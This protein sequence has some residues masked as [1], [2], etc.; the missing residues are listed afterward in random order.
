MKQTSEQLEQDLLAYVDGRLCPADAARI[1]VY[2]AN[3]DPEQSARVAG[4]IADRERLRALPPLRAPRDLAERIMERV[5]RASLLG[6]A[7]HHSSI[8]PRRW[9]HHHMA[10]AA[11]LIFVFGLFGAFIIHSVGQRHSTW[12]PNPIANGGNHETGIP[13]AMAPATKSGDAALPVAF[14]DKEHTVQKGASTELVVK[15]G[16]GTQFKPGLDSSEN[17]V[18]GTYNLTVLEATNQIDAVKANFNGAPNSAA[19]L[20][21]VGATRRDYVAGSPVIVVL[22]AR[23]GSD[24]Q[25]LRSLIANFL[26]TDPVTADRQVALVSRLNAYDTNTDLNANAQALGAQNLDRKQVGN[27]NAENNRG[28]AGIQQQFT[29]RNNDDQNAYANQY[30]VAGPAQAL[31][32]NAS[33][34]VRTQLQRVATEPYRN[35]KAAPRS[36]IPVAFLGDN[37]A[38]Y[39]VLLR[40]EQL[41]QVTNQF[42]V[43]SIA[44][45]NTGYVIGNNTLGANRALNYGIANNGY[46]VA[47]GGNLILNGSNTLSATGNS[48]ILNNGNAN[49]ANTAGTNTTTSLNSAGPSPINSKD[50]APSAG[51]SGSNVEAATVNGTLN[52]NANGSGSANNFSGGTT[53]TGGTLSAGAGASGA[54][55]GLTFAP[56]A[57]PTPNPAPG[58]N[59]APTVSEDNSHG[60]QNVQRPV[61]GLTKGSEFRQNGGMTEEQPSNFK[62]D[63]ALR[64]A[65]Q[66]QGSRTVQ[67]SERA[68]GV[69]QSE[70]A[71]ATP[72]G[73]WVEC[74][75]KMIPNASVP[76]PTTSYNNTSN[77]NR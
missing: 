55:G 46:L 15:D 27:F 29:Q 67:A 30:Q 12:G 58:A 63:A 72:V 45:G 39:R 69:A 77:T 62:S 37:N 26:E 75:I 3:T 38:P 34:Q 71:A 11:G 64:A 73:E 51:K 49:F 47:N 19:A 8:A 76:T 36:E 57:P 5:E 32:E 7:E 6:D 9:Y 74:I 4:M 25:R 50:G 1:E 61:T 42:A 48:I 43:H 68:Q 10:I 21:Y 20:S 18:A 60:I 31:A 33:G 28:A 23:D 66:L 65:D 54:G 24:Y 70:A 22:L 56:A 13:V 53:L 14:A 17:A 35:S 40:P 16:T 44:R 2:L 41:N 52:V 59:P